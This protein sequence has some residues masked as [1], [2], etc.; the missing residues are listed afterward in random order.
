VELL[1][2]KVLKVLILHLVL[3]PH[4]Q[5]AAVAVLMM[6]R[7]LVAAVQVAVAAIMK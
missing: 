2:L 4:Q 5:A 1:P 6:L 3:L 7:H